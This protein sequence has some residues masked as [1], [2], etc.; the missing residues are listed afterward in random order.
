MVQLLAELRPAF[1]VILVDSPPLG[2]GVDPYVLGTCTG[3]MLLVLRTGATD[4]ELTRANL[5]VLDKLPVRILGAVL[6]DVPRGGMYY[7]Y[8]SYLAGYATE[9]EQDVAAR[10]LAAVD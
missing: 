1:D 5:E 10:Q 2:G 4:K 9:D 3:S 8:Y 7:R 6:N